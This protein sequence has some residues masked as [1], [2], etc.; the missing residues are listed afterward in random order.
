MVETKYGV[1]FKIELLHRYYTQL[2]CPDFSI[3]PSLQTK[4]VLAG[5]QII[6]KPYGHQLWA[7]VQLDRN[8]RPFPPLANNLQL[9]FFLYLKNSRFFNYTNLPVS[10]PSRKLYYFTNRNST[11]A[12]GKNHLSLNIQAYS[13]TKTYEPGELALNGSGLVFKA[14]RLKESTN[15]VAF[16]DAAYW[17]QVDGQRYASERDA[18][19][20]MPALS[21]YTLASAAASAAILVRGYNNA[22]GN[23]TTVVWTK[24]E[25][26][27]GDVPSFP[28]DLSA[29]PPGKY[30]LTVNGE[31]QLIYL[32]DELSSTRPFAVVDIF[33]EDSLSAANQLVDGDGHL[34]SPLYTLFFLNRSTLWKYV[35]QSGEA[36]SIT[37]TAGVYQFSGSPGTL[38][39]QAPI[40]LSENALNLTLT[41]GALEYTRIACAT[42]ER[43]SVCTRDSVDYPCS[44]IFLN[45]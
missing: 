45:N 17:E 40:P 15:A 12:N 20:W 1:L 9:T 16:P 41:I 8:N 22:T 26:F 33:Q 6:A 3:V 30:E 43:L 38:F 19:Q 2:S 39:S 36:G 18:L 7:G 11:S 35:L 14:L 32:N 37:D 44:E 31:K 25:T 21:T 23:Y 42:P 28:L 5:Q 4:A 34:L 29:L 24:T 10:H 13:A 27:G